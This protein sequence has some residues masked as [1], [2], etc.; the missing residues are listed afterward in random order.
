MY[1]ITMWGPTGLDPISAKLLGGAG[2]HGSVVLMYHSISPGDD[3]PDWLWS[4]SYRRFV[5]QLDLL[6]AAGWTTV[7][8]RDLKNPMT[9]AA[10]T[11]VITFDD[12]FADSYAA[13]D[14]LRKRNMCATWF[15][16]SGV[17]G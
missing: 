14:V 8:V 11:A 2:T 6:Q 7:C 5:A 10:R 9:V 4:I 1:D 12:G 17:V 13:F 16:A 15:I 3:T